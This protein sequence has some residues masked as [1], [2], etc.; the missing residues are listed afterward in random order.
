ML[1][2]VSSH[3]FLCLDFGLYRAI[4]KSLRHLRPLRYSSRDGHAKGEH[5]NR[6][7]DISS[8]CP[9][10]Q[11]LDISTLCDAADVN[12]VINFLPHTLQHL[13]V[14]SSYCL[15]S[16]DRGS[17]RRSL[18]STARFCNVCG[19]NM[20]TGLTSTASPSVDI[21]SNCKVGQKIG[22]SLLLLTCSPSAWPFRLL[23][24]RGRKSRRDLRITLY[25]HMEHIYVNIW[26]LTNIT[27]AILRKDVTKFLCTFTPH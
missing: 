4:H 2:I 8:F 12:P 20:I 22:V 26:Q 19:R 14:D 17:W 6:G 9:T 23:Y 1:H 11:V 18:L 25:F 15:Q 7:R 21:S 27:L 24:H 13:A 10:L 5:V 3:T 16:C